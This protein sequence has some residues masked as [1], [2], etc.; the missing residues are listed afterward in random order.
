MVVVPKDIFNVLSSAVIQTL[1]VCSTIR[2]LDS[3]SE[4]A[5][6][7]LYV[8]RHLQSLPFGVE[9]QSFASCDAAA[10]S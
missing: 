10:L 8:P 9:T 5:Q 6:M 7:E 3:Q 2:S 1:S 4:Q